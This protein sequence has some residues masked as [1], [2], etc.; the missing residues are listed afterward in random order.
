MQP[1]D[2]PQALPG[3]ILAATAEGRLLYISENVVKYLG[4]STVSVYVRA[5]VIVL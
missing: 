4:Y 2:A 3:F 1:F 5:D